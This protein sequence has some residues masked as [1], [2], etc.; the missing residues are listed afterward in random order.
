MGLGTGPAERFVPVNS[1]NTVRRC[2][3]ATCLLRE[4]QAWGW[5]LRLTLAH[6]RGLCLI[7]VWLGLG[8]CLTDGSLLMMM[9]PAELC[10]PESHSSTPRVGSIA[11]GWDV[12]NRRRP[13][14]SIVRQVA[15]DACHAQG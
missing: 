2:W 7:W 12:G 10:A 1:L 14:G 6:A 15:D 5:A 8:A 11:S 13:E 4:G 3:H 9:M